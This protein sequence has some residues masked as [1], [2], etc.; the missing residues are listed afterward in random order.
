MVT[1]NVKDKD[2]PLPGVIVM[3]KGT[4]IGT[5][6]D[7]NGDYG[8]VVPYNNKELIFSYIGYKTT[9][10]Q[11]GSEFANITLEPEVL[12]LQEVVV[13]GYGVTRRLSGSGSKCFRYTRFKSGD[14][15]TGIKFNKCCK[16]SFIYY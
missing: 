7:L 3:V 1:G 5:V 12:A 2:G 16:C 11:V 15:N 6:S 13:T 4:T 8:L 9:E 14:K 10:I